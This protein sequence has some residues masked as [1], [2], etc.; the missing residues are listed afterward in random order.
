MPFDIDTFTAEI[1]KNG[2]AKTSNFDVLVAREKNGDVNL[3]Q[4]M[5]LRIDSITLPGRT[6]A[7]SSEEVWHYGLDERRAAGNRCSE[8]TMSIILSAD[9]AERE[10]FERWIDD[11]VGNYRNQLTDTPTMYDVGYFE[12]YR[13][14]VQISVY[15]EQ[16]GEAVL[17]RKLQLIDAI[18]SSIGNIDFGWDQTSVAKLSVTFSY[19][20]YV[21]ITNID[22]QSPGGTALAG[23]TPVGRGGI[24]HA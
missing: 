4:S 19:T 14:T 9:Y 11:M 15:D 5:V 6:V 17:V 20:R 7:L 22:S 8:V 1:A 10:Y 24:G 12:D 2:F 13:G 16:D 23:A 21:D 3:E 18:P